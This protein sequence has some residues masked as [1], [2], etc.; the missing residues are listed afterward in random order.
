MSKLQPLLA[1]TEDAIIKDACGVNVNSKLYGERHGE[2]R[3]RFFDSWFSRPRVNTS[4]ALIMPMCIIKALL[5]GAF[6][7]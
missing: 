5:R 4:R 1:L 3:L 6:C 2:L 7:V